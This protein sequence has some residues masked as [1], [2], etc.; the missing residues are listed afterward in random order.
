M[1]SRVEVLGASSRVNVT[2][3]YGKLEVLNPEDGFSTEACLSMPIN[4][5][6]EDSEFTTKRRLD[7]KEGKLQVLGPKENVL[8]SPIKSDSRPTSASRNHGSPRKKCYTPTKQVSLCTAKPIS[9]SGYLSSTD[10]TEEKINSSIKPSTSSPADTDEKE[11]IVAS[12]ENGDNL[13]KG[14]SEDSNDEEDSDDE[15]ERAPLELLAEF[16][17]AVMDQDYETA[18]HLCKLILIYEPENP[19][20]KEFSPLIDQM[21]Q[22]ENEQE[23]ASEDGEETCEDSSESDS[24][25]DEDIEKSSDDTS[26]SENEEED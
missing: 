9:Q 21:L 8:I 10:L 26:E 19:E 3:A 20:A 17:K 15:K 24:N 12:S 7:C 16:L 2:K 5:S 11:T 4:C 18:Q 25:D 1:M 14:K 23:T 13:V 6:F 22:R